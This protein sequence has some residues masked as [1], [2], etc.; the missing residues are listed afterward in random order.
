MAQ[1]PTHQK[2]RVNLPDSLFRRTKAAAALR[3][4]TLTEATV[5]ALKAWLELHEPRL[6]ASSP[7]TVD[8]LQAALR[9][10]D[11]YELVLSHCRGAEPVL[12]LPFRT[13][14]PS[15]PLVCPSCKGHYPEST[16]KIEARRR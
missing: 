3:G 12:V 15:F 13:G 6:P 9:T 10:P 5:E 1:N 16:Y 11:D 7:T 8:T 2:L 14:L 4:Q